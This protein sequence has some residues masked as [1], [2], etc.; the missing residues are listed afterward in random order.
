MLCLNAGQDKGSR[1]PYRVCRRGPH[2]PSPALDIRRKEAATRPCLRAGRF[3]DGRGE[4]A[5]SIERGDFKGGS[6]PLDVGAISEPPATLIQPDRL[7]HGKVLFL[8]IVLRP[9][10]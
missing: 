5:V 6:G 3:N 4:R 7:F 2:H 10:I 9:G 8:D 1:L